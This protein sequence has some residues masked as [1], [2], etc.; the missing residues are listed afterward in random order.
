MYKEPLIAAKCF[1]MGSVPVGRHP[2]TH[3]MAAGTEK[4]P[5]S[6]QNRRGWQQQVTKG[7]T[8]PGQPPWAMEQTPPLIWG[9]T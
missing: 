7:A 3:T 5:P 9:A 1:K 8:H 2:Y 6:M 4:S